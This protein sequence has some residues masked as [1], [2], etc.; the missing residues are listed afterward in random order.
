MNPR[1]NFSV[2]SMDSNCSKIEENV[3]PVKAGWEQIIVVVLSSH[4][5]CIIP[6]SGLAGLA[7][8]RAGGTGDCTSGVSG[9]SDVTESTASRRSPSFMRRF[10]GEGEFAT[11]ILC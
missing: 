10:C 6:V 5:N 7:E 11:D 1:K 8:E 9:L 4:L 2:V 3:D